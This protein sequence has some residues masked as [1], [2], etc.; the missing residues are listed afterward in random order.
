MKKLNRQEWA[1]LLIILVYSFIPAVGGLFR[2]FEFAGGPAIAPGNP[3]ALASPAP[4]ILHILSSSL[5]LLLGAVQFL[6]G[7]RR[8]SP[9]IHR[10]LGPAVVVSGC[11]SAA[12]GVWMT[13]FYTFPS[14]LQGVLL[15]WARIFLGLSMIGLIV[16]SVV[17]IRS[18]NI[19]LHGASMFRAYA[20]GQGAS[21]QAFMGIGWMILSG[22]EA[23]GP[24]RE[25]IMLS[26]WILNFLAAE[27]LIGKF[28]MPKN[29][30]V[31]TKSL[32]SGDH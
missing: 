24:V 30:P 3:R 22:T 23:L 13:H 11:I 32:P 20:I 16:C 25:G 21:T 8:H 10:T 9:A 1:L 2:I 7:I 5:F 14:E 27:Y 18:R 26:A 12:T 4:I 6:P 31:E 19:S 15:Y 17:A 29:L 28:L